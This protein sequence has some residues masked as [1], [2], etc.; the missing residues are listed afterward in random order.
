MLRFVHAQFLYADGVEVFVQVPGV[1]EGQHQ[2]G[3]VH[4]E[5]RLVLPLDASRSELLLTTS[6]AHFVNPLG[7]FSSSNVPPR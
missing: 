7:E 5:T 4:V 3:D 2:P 1:E 6:I